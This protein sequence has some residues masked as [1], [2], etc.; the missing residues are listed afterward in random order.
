MSTM[1]QRWMTS[2]AAPARP[3]PSVAQP[4]GG[5]AAPAAPAAPA[6]TAGYASD[7]FTLSLPLAA[8]PQAQAEGSAADFPPVTAAEFDAQLALEAVGSGGNAMPVVRKGSR[9]E[10]V[11][12]LQSKLREAG[13]DPGPIDGIFGPLT[14]AAVVAYQKKKGLA[15]DGIVGKQTWGSMG[16]T[17]AASSGSASAGGLVT[18]S[19]KQISAK[20]ADQYDRMVAAAKA[21]GVDLRITSGYRSRAEQEHLYALYK[22][23]KGNIAAK[24]GTSN[25]E[26]GTAIDFANTPGAYAWLKKNAPK[27]GLHNFPPE[28][29][30]YSLTGG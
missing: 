12:T 9:G 3:L 20:I 27:F 10:A 17:V 13:C 6:G 29:W 19:G 28:P 21:D 26:T 2:P 23:G 11:K 7:A 22:A 18:R 30:H 4:A 5:A 25:H 15:V 8:G 14:H 24:P 16:H 1:L